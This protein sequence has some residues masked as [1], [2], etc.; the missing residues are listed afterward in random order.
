[1]EGRSGGW[2]GS[3][4][5]PAWEQGSTN[6][7]HSD[8]QGQTGADRRQFERVPVPTAV[9]SG[10]DKVVDLSMGGAC[11]QGME[12]IQQGEKVD[13][14]LTDANLFHTA[15]IEAEVVWKN[16]DRVGLRWLQMDDREHEWLRARLP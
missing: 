15:M 10:W 4:Q 16:A 8:E 1:M 13:L 14:I 6:T 11:L 3:C 5:A 7:S 9:A 12:S 2:H